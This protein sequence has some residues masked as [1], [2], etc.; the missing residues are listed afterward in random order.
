[1]KKIIEL[2]PLIVAVIIIA[3]LAV[4][5]AAGVFDAPEEITITSSTL[6]EVIQTAKLTTAKYI[7]H[8]IAKAHI[9][10][11]EDGYVLY[12]AIVKPNVDFAEITYDIDDDAKKVTVIIPEKFTFDVELLEDENHQIYYYPKNP[13]HW[14]GKDATYICKTDAKQ[15]AEAN[16]EL[17]AKAQESLINT[18]E[19]LLNP[20]LS[21]NDYTFTVEISM[22]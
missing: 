9:E 6:T 14:T 10:G 17:I 11:K 16:T 4:L 20:I 2:S 1:M 19:A 18:I 15:K 7:Q 13:D 5:F 22:N 12:Y 3:A 21:R 8:G